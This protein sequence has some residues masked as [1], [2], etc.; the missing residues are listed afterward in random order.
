VWPPCKLHLVFPNGKGRPI[1]HNNLIRRYFYPVLESAKLP[2]IRFHDLRHTYASLLIAQ[3]E[4]IKHIQSQLGHS[5]P[6]V[7]LNAYDQPD[8]TSQSGGSL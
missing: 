6:T 4:N 2:E 7:T 8:E 1:D 3:G 5:S